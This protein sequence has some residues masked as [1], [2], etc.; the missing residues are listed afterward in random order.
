MSAGFRTLKAFRLSLGVTAL[1]LCGCANAQQQVGEHLY[2]VPEA[3]LVPQGAYPFFLSQSRS[4]GFIFILNPD[5]GSRHKR[6]VLVQD[7]EEVCERANG[8]GYV[9]QTI[10]SSQTIEWKGRGW[11]KT[12]DDT[13]WTY[14]PNARSAANAPFVSCH[15]MEQEEHPGLCKAT[16]ALGDLALTFSFNDD[17]LAS[18]EATYQQAASMLRSWEV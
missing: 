3:N 10:C 1:F 9:S 6:S 5:A 7:R 14:S 18:L 16:L 12:G 2:D 15:E 8:R 11:L 4:D 13:F 17:E